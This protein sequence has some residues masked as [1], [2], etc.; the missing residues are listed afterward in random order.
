MTS[1]LRPGPKGTPVPAGVIVLRLA[2][3]S[4]D[5]IESRRAN[6]THFSLSTDD[7]E[8]GLQSLTV[9]AR[10]LTSAIKARELM[11]DHKASYRLAL[12]LSV[13]EIRAVRVSADFP[14]FPLDIVWDT[15]DRPGAE[16]H[17]GIIGLM[18]PPGG[19]RMKYKALRA[20]LAQIAIVEILPDIA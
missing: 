19:E 3:L 16:G 11:G 2:K 9:W 13:D 10:L 15:D 14:V 12:Y 17:A 1:T 8:S 6:E 7:E 5:A 4:K 20:R 18:R